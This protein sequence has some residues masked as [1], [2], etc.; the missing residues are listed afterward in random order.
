MRKSILVVFLLV[1]ALALTGCGGKKADTATDTSASSTTNAEDANA[2]KAQVEPLVVGDRSANESET[3]EP[4]PT[5]SFVPEELKASIAAKRPTILYF[6]DSSN[7]STVN[8]TMIDAVRAQN[9]GLIDLALF[10]M[11]RYTTT[12]P[13]GVV[14]VSPSVSNDPGAQQAIQLA[15]TIGAATLPYVVVTDGQ[16]Y[17]IW[18]SHGL[19][20]KAL[21]DRE[22]QRATQ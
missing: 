9:S 7:T 4:F 22:V 5:G 2:K 10:D 21:L 15:R 13:D 16:G 11:G 19:L 20:D 14:S 3:F 17:I 8:R 6:Y 12:S 18:K 1:V